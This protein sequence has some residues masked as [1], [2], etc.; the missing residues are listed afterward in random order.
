MAVARGLALWMSIEDPIRV[1]ELKLRPERLASIRREVRARPEQIVEVREF[2]KPRV[3]EICGTLPAGIG[4]RLLASAAWRRWLGLFAGA[5]AVRT[6][7]ISGFL[8]L[9]SVAALKR[10][11][12]GTLRYSLER[13][14]IGAWLA[15][16]AELAAQDY[17]VA[18]E[19][20]DSQRLVKGYGDT[21]E[22]GL[23]NFK[24]IAAAARRVAGRDGAAALVARLCRAAQ[25]DD[26]SEALGRELA[27]LGSV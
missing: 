23:Q 15:C 22:R 13:T 5:R 3:E 6:T 14:E 2:L 25:A 7:S 18:V 24:R 10:W 8:L 16:V 11:R 20:A 26:R 9:R 1:A 17:H 4:R 12:R 27:A 21:H 19:L